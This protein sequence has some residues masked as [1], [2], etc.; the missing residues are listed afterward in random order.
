VSH[1]LK[2]QTIDHLFDLLK[3]IDSVWSAVSETPEHIYFEMCCVGHAET[4]MLKLAHE[5]ISFRRNGLAFVVTKAPVPTVEDP[6]IW[7][8]TEMITAP[9]PDFDGCF[10]VSFNTPAP[11]PS[12]PQDLD[13]YHETIEKLEARAVHAVFGDTL[14]QT[15]KLHWESGTTLVLAWK[16]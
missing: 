5:H 4:L 6:M 15:L 13:G 2:P 7:A 9:G 12:Y 11:M 14:P 1:H 16:R 10:K 3:S 8:I